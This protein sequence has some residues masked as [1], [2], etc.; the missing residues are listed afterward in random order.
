M[1]TRV[2][3]ASLFGGASVAFWGGCAL[4]VLTPEFA[5]RIGGITTVGVMAIGALTAPHLARFA[6]RATEP[7]WS[8]GAGAVLT[9]GLYVLSA[10][11]LA[12]LVLFAMNRDAS[13]SAG[14]TERGDLALASL[15]FTLWVG[16]Y[17]LPFALPFGIG[18]AW[19]LFRLNPPD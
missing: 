14:W 3:A 2:L 8:I 1:R 17:V 7:W 6:P 11:V 15:R 12:V 16:L 19:A 5:L 9:G 10:C 4:L 13:I 18:A